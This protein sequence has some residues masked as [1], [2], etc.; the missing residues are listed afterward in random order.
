VALPWF[1]LRLLFLQQKQVGEDDAK[2]QRQG[3]KAESQSKTTVQ[4]YVFTV[5]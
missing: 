1:P 5:E 2:E 3:I 4:Y